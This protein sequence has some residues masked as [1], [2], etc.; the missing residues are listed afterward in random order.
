MNN[1]HKG[2]TM[3]EIALRAGVTV[4]AVSKA[5][6][7]RSD[8]SQK[9]KEEIKKIAHELGYIPSFIAKNLR[10]GTSNIIALVFNDFY[11]PYFSISSNT[12]LNIL[13][14]KG[15]KCQLIFCNTTLMT[16]E[17]IPYIMIN[18]YC[19]IISFV[20]PTNEVAA[21]FRQRQIP[22]TLVGINSNN[23]DID[24]IYTDDYLGGVEVAKE[25]IQGNYNHA[26]YIS[27]SPSETS[28]R[29]MSGFESLCKKQQKSYD[30]YTKNDYH[31]EEIL[32]IIDEK[33]IDFIFCFSDALAIQ[34]IEFL[35]K[36]KYVKELRVVG[37]D[38]LHKYY[39]FSIEIDSVGSDL[40]KI[41]EFACTNIISKINEENDLGTTTNKMFPTYFV[42]K[43]EY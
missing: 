23:K 1:S 29:R 32:N 40:D 13:K 7:D 5:L 28:T 15:F 14:E 10:S 19:G 31:L 35:K 4:D 25:F 36:E 17:D 8:I 21:F 38:N 2:V 39:P 3:R 43:T 42:K 9:K 34:L 6:R 26:L 27:N 16:T 41:L 22:F 24:C 18:N 11:N 20:E 30:C 12:I 37:F 33:N